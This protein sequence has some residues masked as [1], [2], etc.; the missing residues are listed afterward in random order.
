MSDISSGGTS[1]V[2]ATAALALPAGLFCELQTDHLR[3]L[4]SELV[5]KSAE[6][7]KPNLGSSGCDTWLWFSETYMLNSHEI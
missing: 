2:G 4:C 1:R 7:L 3:D 5:I 6:L